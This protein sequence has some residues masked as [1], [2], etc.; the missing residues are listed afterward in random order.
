MIKKSISFF[1]L[2]FL[3]FSCGK[4]SVV[5]SPRVLSLSSKSSRKALL[6]GILVERFSIFPIFLSD[7]FYL[8]LFTIEISSLFSGRLLQQNPL[9]PIL[10]IFKKEKYMNF[11]RNKIKIKINY[12]ILIF[13][14]ILIFNIFF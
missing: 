8:S 7:L 3:N 6:F 2:L 10:F 1:G 12:I 4:V 11:K 14:L 13:L 9:F 5:L